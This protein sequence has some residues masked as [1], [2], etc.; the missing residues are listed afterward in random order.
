M[1][2]QLI[3]WLT[4]LFTAFWLVAATLAVFVVEE[5]LTEAMDRSLKEAAERLVP[6][7]QN[8]LVTEKLTGSREIAQAAKV[9]R[10][11]F[12]LYQVRDARGDVVLRS[13]DAPEKPFEAPLA[14]GFWKSTEF[15][16][17]TSAGPNGFFLQAAD[18]LKARDS[19]L[20]ESSNSL[21]LPLLALIPML[22]VT[23]I[24]V[25]RRSLSPVRE[26]SA[27]IERKDTGNM[28]AVDVSALPPELRQIAVSVNHLLS[29]LRAA[30]DAEREF[31]SNSAHE[32][33]TPIAGALAH[34]ELLL[35]ELAGRP[36]EH[37]ASQIKRSLR[38]LS[39]TAEKLLQLSRADAGLGFEEAEADLIPILDMV[40]GDFKLYDR[41]NRLLYTNPSGADLRGPYS[42][43][44][45]AIAVRNLIENALKHGNPD[46]AV[47]I[48]V[49][50]GGVVRIVNGS[51]IVAPED[52][53]HL[54]QRFVRGKSASPGSGLGLSI[55]DRLLAQMNAELLLCSPATGRE[56]GF[57]AVIRFRAA[58]SRRLRDGSSPDG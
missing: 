29:R 10:G 44:A 27:E 33:R 15:Q 7:L 28:Q 47:E 32:L 38:D 46:T 16:Y 5:E 53:T 19:A 39:Q 23:V 1:T 18:L 13:D 57:E 12:L 24:A 6:V 58:P 9:A 11:Q 43:D 17:Y 51:D 25:V 8:E 34:A 4:G 40:V 42:I 56:N 35:V 55:A 2:R 48:E 50:P 30:L 14:P 3:V 26:V 52:L 36:G 41:A 49:Q 31:T 22:I 20:R 37:R 54:R 45:F 21:F